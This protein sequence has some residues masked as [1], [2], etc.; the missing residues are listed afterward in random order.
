MQPASSGW[1]RATAAALEG[2]RHTVEPDRAVSRR[3]LNTAARNAMKGLRLS[4]SLRNLLGELVGVWGEVMVKDKIL[5][6]PS[7]DYLVARTGLSERAVR[8]GIGRL[9]EL[10]LVSVKDSANGKRFAIR[11]K[12]GDLL[13]AYGF[14]LTPLYNRRA[15]FVELIAEQTAEIERRERMFDEITICRRAAQETIAAL[16]EIGGRFLTRF[17]Q[18]VGRTP[19][20]SRTAAA[21]AA[22]AVEPVLVEWRALRQELE[23][24]FYLAASGGKNGRLI[25]SKPSESKIQRLEQEAPRGAEVV[26]DPSP[27][28]SALPV[29]LVVEACPSL[30]EYVEQPKD[31]VDLVAAGRVLRSTLGAHATVWSEAVEALGPVSAAAAVCLVLQL[32]E[33]DAA[34]GQ[35]QR[36][37]NPG[38]YLRSVVRMIKDGRMNLRAELLALVRKNTSPPP[39]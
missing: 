39:F 20:R 2:R 25:E 19:R 28:T 32:Y 17:E 24:T 27:P 37:H 13:D 35:A 22:E 38:G 10:C 7:N 5:V 30:L 26:E 3:E 23:E 11:N 21:A 15:E 4:P 9:V 31:E 6:Y 12:A 14:D 1:R 36:I 34:R 29:A 33:N 8:Y 16:K 18:L